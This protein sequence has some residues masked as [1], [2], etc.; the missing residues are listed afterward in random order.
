MTSAKTTTVSP[1]I[2]EAIRS[3]K[4]LY[5]RAVDTKSWAE[6]ER[7]ALPNA[8]L[9]Y[10][11]S[12]NGLTTDASDGTNL[13]SFNSRDDFVAFFKKA[14]E[15]LQTIHMVNSGSFERISDDEVKAVFALVT[16]GGPTCDSKNGH[17]TAG[18]YYNEVY[19]NVDG[20]WFLKSIEFE[21]VYNRV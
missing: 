3:K 17:V 12:V 5:C 6:F 7:I 13:P 15:P 11:N 18:G 2:I 21:K 14:F 19:K 9:V 8:T 20:E 4:T 10:K 1:E 16:H